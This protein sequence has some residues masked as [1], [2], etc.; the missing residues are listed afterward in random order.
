[1]KFKRTM[2][3]ILEALG[4]VTKGKQDIL[5]WSGLNT[6]KEWAT[7]INETL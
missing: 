1:M 7:V 2:F 3:V 5:V 6:L 4:M